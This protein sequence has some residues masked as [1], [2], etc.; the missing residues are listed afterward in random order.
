MTFLGYL[1]K[2]GNTSYYTDNIVNPSVFNAGPACSVQ[3]K[4]QIPVFSL[5]FNPIDFWKVASGMKIVI[6]D[7]DNNEKY[8]LFNEEILYLIQSLASGQTILENGLFTSNFK[9]VKA[10]SQYTLKLASQE[11]ID[12][13]G[14]EIPEII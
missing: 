8:N 9:I 4:G 7:V 14:I 5:T 3:F 6:E 1:P 10:G 12:N 11:D 2:K 13:I